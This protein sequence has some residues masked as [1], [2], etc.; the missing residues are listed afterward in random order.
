M[1]PRNGN[2]KVTIIV[3]LLLCA[4]VVGGSL[5]FRQADKSVALSADALTYETFRGDFVSTVNESGDIESSRNEEIRCEVK[6]QGKAGTAILEVIQEGTTVKKGD[7]LCQLD[8]SVLKDQLVEQKIKVAQD[9]ASVIQARSDLDTAKRILN[10]FEEGV[11][12]QELAALKAEVAL[13]EETSRRS[14]QVEEYSRTLNRKG[15]ITRT[16]LEA[17]EFAREKAN[18][19][20]KLA[21]Q[22]LA[23]YEKFTKDRMVAE[24]SAEIEKQQANLEAADYTWELSQARE[25]EIATQIANCRVT[26]PSDGMVIYANETDRRGDAS[27]VIE[28]GAL[29][30]DGQ[31]IFRLPDP[32]QMQV[33]ATVSDSKINDV[34]EGQEVLVRVDT[35]PESPVAGKVRRVSAF[36]LPRRWYQ[37]PIEYEVFV[38]IV[39]LN[40]LIRPGL[41]GKVEIFTK[42]V[43][44]VIQAPV[45]S[46]I[47]HED[48]YFVLVKAAESL[49]VREVEIGSNNDRFA[50]IKKGLEIGELVL[51]DPD[52]YRDVVEFPS[53]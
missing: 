32:T 40:D 15:Y 4:T 3:A 6:S 22:K 50:V 28:E 36:P 20:E 9:R 19:D 51:I 44:D 35:D 33:K 18:L 53:S 42:R 2:V 13:A 1:N 30:R 47:R 46:L 45:S 14:I 21:K 27:F 16:Q 41:R 48:K 7:F 26:A 17:D 10:E 34:V 37:A 43:G 29:L 39:E 52:P 49:D 25:K 12:A 11:Y 31:P 38:D 24:F 23:V 5:Y 8:D